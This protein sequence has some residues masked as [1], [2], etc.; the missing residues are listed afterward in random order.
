MAGWERSW[1]DRRFLVH[2]IA[3][4]PVASVACICQAQI[5]YPAALVSRAGVMVDQCFAH[6]PS[7]LLAV[8]VISGSG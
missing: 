3:G 2:A 5:M 8:A 1:C 6:S 4:V 7:S